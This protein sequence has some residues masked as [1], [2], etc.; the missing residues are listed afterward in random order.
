MSTIVASRELLASREDVWKFLAEPNHLSDWWPGVDGVRP[1]RQGLAPGARWEVTGRP[2]GRGFLGSLLGG[3][4]T[5]RMLMI[6]EVRTNELVRF[7]FTE[8]NIEAKLVLEPADHDHTNAT[9]TV[10]GA[11][12]RRNASFAR[13]ALSRLHALCQTGAEL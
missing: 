4:S 12:L 2:Q 5:S 10:D 1:N 8:D 7:L 9:L 11:W 6:L 3:P 13:S